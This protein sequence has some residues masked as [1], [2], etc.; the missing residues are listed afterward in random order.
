MT[1]H[2]EY[3]VPE[4]LQFGFPVRSKGSTWEVIEG[5]KQDDFAKEKIRVTTAELLSER[6]EVKELL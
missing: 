3:G 2:G 5:L 4:G 6:E 1:S